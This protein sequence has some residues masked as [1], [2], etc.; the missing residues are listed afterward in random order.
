MWSVRN[1]VK[2]FITI[3]ISNFCWNYYFSEEG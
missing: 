2:V 3:K 1:V